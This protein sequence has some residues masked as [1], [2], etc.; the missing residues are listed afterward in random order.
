MSL[1][2]ATEI[3]EAR[4]VLAV[5]TG[6][7]PFLIH[8][9]SPSAFSP[10]LCSFLS[11]PMT[12]RFDYSIHTIRS[13]LIINLIVLAFVTCPLVFLASLVSGVCMKAFAVHSQCRIPACV[14]SIL[15]SVT[16]RGTFI[17]N[18]TGVLGMLV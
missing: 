13:H 15:N 3:L 16:K 12:A 5:V 4:A 10:I 17:G 6:Q 14:R 2:G 8:I 1:D 11:N 18:F 9:T 7:F